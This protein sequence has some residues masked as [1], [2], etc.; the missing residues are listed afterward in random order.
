MNYTVIG[1]GRSGLSA[2]LLAKELGNNV[3]VTE[4]KDREEYPEAYAKLQEAG[5]EC[6][7]YGNTERALENCDCIIT[8]PG[9]PPTAWIIKEAEKR[10]IKIIAELEYARSLCP[11]NPLIAI[12]GTNGK[13][14]TTTLIAYILNRAG[15]KAIALG[16]IG[17]PLSAYVKGL[18]PDTILVAE[19]SSYQLD[20]IETFRPDVAL[21]LNI[22][23]DHLA[24]HGSLENYKLAKFKITMNQNENNL[25]ILNY[26]DE[27]AR[28][29][30]ACTKAKIAGFSVSPV[31]WGIYIKGG[32]LVFRNRPAAGLPDD[33][34]IEEEI[35]MLIEEIRIPGMH[36]AYNS[37]AAALAAR[38]F[39]IRNEDI[40]DSLMAFQGVEHRLEHVAIID[41][42]EYI[43][44]SKATNINA[45]WYALSSYDK[46]I[47]WIAG[48]RGD[49]NDYSALDELVQKNVKEIIAIGEEADAIFNYFCLMK[50]CLKE[51]S[52]E[53]AVLKARANAEP[54]DIVLFTPACKSFDM[55]MNY[56]HRGEVFK[57]IV[58]SLK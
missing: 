54:G 56:E 6:E 46:P 36:N 18:D 51:N 1:A 55:F 34:H 35:L 10:G 21:I 2:A 33:K 44:D 8:S 19:V 22:T 11:D 58:L 38:A 57:D 39:E 27:T 7:F 29:A 42:V 40:R 14:T 45:T 37:M 26:D 30:A 15:K 31:D 12:T 4:S 52:L 24:Y 9:V 3:F 47:I 41:G 48:G 53:S 5:I 25:L 17:T 28:G 49:S 16:N 23:P 43:N 50:R 32:E 13:T 20:R